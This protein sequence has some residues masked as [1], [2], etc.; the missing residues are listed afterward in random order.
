MP[1]RDS[2]ADILDLATSRNDDP[3][4]SHFPHISLNSPDA[5]CEKQSKILLDKKT[6]L[7]ICFIRKSEELM[8]A[9]ASNTLFSQNL[10]IV[11]MGNSEGNRHK[12][13]VVY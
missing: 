12:T 9:Q 1:R 2:R 7:I 10:S 6:A 5:G 3:L 8:F 11:G 13:K 4:L